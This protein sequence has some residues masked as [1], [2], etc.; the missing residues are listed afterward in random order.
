MKTEPFLVFIPSFHYKML[1]SDFFFSKKL[2]VWFLGFFSP[3]LFLFLQC[4]AS[5][6]V[7]VGSFG[8]P[9]GLEGLA[10]F[11]GFYL[12]VCDLVALVPI[13]SGL[14]VWSSTCALNH[15]HARWPIIIFSFDVN[16]NSVDSMKG[17]IYWSPFCTSDVRVC[18]LRFWGLYM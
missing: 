3:P 4:A 18:T 9:A 11:L 1:C 16:E 6:D 17:A 12:F 14:F 15:A 10:H 5:M 8:D 13:W 2:F 7:G